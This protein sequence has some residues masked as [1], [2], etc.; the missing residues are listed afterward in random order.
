M[1]I[2]LQAQRFCLRKRRDNGE[3]DVRG[4]DWPRGISSRERLFGSWV[5]V[6][7]VAQVRKDLV[8]QQFRFKMVLL[9]L[10]ECG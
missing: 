1:R 8:Q 5:E 3:V 9:A 4:V 6:F 10:G 7:L 2:T